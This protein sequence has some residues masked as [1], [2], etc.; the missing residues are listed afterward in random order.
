MTKSRLFLVLLSVLFVITG[1][2]LFIVLPCESSGVN[3]PP[4]TICNV[5]SPPCY[6][7]LFL[8]V[9]LASAVLCLT[10]VVSGDRLE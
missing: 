2:M 8:V 4:N 7:S 5:L 9:C 1:L 10:M 6:E 3:C